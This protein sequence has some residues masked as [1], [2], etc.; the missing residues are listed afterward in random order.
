M[1]TYNHTYIY[2]IYTFN[3]TINNMLPLKNTSQERSFCVTPLVLTINEIKSKRRF[4]RAA[5]I[6]WF[7]CRCH[8]T[9]LLI[10]LIAKHQNLLSKICIRTKL[11]QLIM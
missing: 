2:N 7:C 10:L 8:S 11:E 6:P 4:F 5:I 1:N 9:H 3:L